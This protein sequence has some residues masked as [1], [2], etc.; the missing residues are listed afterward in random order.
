MSAAGNDN[1]GQEA[2]EQL[3]GTG[4]DLSYMQRNAL[5]TGRVNVTLSGKGIPEYDIVEGV[6]G[7]HWKRTPRPS[8]SLHRQ[9]PSAGARSPSGRKYHAKQSP[10]YLGP[11]ARSA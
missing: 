8:D 9:M 11:L 6:A 4:I 7:T 10:Q 3:A 1:L 2:F 5:P